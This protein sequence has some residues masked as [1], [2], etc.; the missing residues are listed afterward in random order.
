MPRRR[1]RAAQRGFTLLEVL[2][3]LAVVAISLLAAMRA[4]GGAQDNAARL[5]E[6]VLA[7][8]CAENFLVEQRLNRVFPSVGTSS[9]SC[10][11]ADASFT[12]AL[13][14]QPTPNP[15]FRRVDLQALDASG[16]SAWHVVT[17]VGNL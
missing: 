10:T 7:A 2:V 13:D 5:R 11:E 9:S 8:Q 14:V 1:S 4:S 3:A 16:W 15:N 12:L 6:S 17:I